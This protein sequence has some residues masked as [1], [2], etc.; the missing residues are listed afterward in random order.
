MCFCCWWNQSRRFN[1][2]L[3]VFFILRIPWRDG[4][5]LLL[6]TEREQMGYSETE[7]ERTSYPFGVKERNGRQGRALFQ[8]RSQCRLSLRSWLVHS[9][10][11]GEPWLDSTIWLVRFE[12]RKVPLG[13]GGVISGKFWWF[14]WDFRM[15]FINVSHPQR[16]TNPFPF[17]GSN[18]WGEV[19]LQYATEWIEI[20][21]NVKMRAQVDP[22]HLSK[23][24]LFTQITPHVKL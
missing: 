3:V 7:N 12:K 5:E 17:P 8:E 18:L 23:G 19:A 10:R 15:R 13:D 22:N 9:K 16:P 2:F 21:K 4:E 6:V 1:N 20:N 24:K 14:R 11:E